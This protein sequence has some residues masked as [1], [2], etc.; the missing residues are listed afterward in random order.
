MPKLIVK[1]LIPMEE[2]SFITILDSTYQYH[3]VSNFNG[4]YELVLPN[5]NH[6]ISFQ[7]LGYSMLQMCM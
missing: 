1:S 2:Q 5:G 4:D 7:Y 6:K 3:T